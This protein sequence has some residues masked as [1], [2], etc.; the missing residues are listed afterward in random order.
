MKSIF[1][2]LLRNWYW[3]LTVL[4]ASGFGF[5]F[6]IDDPSTLKPTKAV[7]FPEKNYQTVR[8]IVEDQIAQP[9]VSELLTLMT[10]R[11]DLA[12]E[13][14]PHF[15]SHPDSFMGRKQ[16]NCEWLMDFALNNNPDPLDSFVIVL[17]SH[18][19]NRPTAG[20]NYMFSAHAEGVSTISLNRIEGKK[21]IERLCKLIDKAIGLSVYGLEASTNKNSVMYKGIRNLR[22]LDQ[23]GHW[24]E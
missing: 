4:I 1:M 24:Y 13:Q 10:N 3:V 20:L 23:A 5:F 9:F 7:S 21:K 12:M 14:G 6:P 19:L 18:D 8:I 15:T 11:H 22:G 17:T 16:Q 2:T